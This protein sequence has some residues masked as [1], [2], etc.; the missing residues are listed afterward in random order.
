M[1][2]VSVDGGTDKT[3]NR[4]VLVIVLYVGKQRFLLP[5]VYED[6]GV[7]FKGESTGAALVQMIRSHLGDENLMKLRGIMVD[8]CPVNG[9]AVKYVNNTLSTFINNHVS[10]IPGRDWE[11]IERGILKANGFV[12]QLPCI[13]H[14]FSMY[15]DSAL[16]LFSRAFRGCFYADDMSARKG[17]YMGMALEE[18]LFVQ[19]DKENK[20]S[21]FFT[22]KRRCRTLCLTMKWT[23]FSQPSLNTVLRWRSTTCLS[24]QPCK[25]CSQVQ[26]RSRRSTVK[27]W[28]VFRKSPLRAAVKKLLFPRA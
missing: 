14:R 13:G 20:R 21:A 24:S 22:E 18:A 1:F 4:F 7:S 27:S 5:P 3:L 25:V 28:K 8:G 11:D 12:T 15:D 26:R 9:V 16:F 10:E 6:R 17:R 2:T 23:A 19:T